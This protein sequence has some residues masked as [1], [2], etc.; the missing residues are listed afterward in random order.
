MHLYVAGLKTT[1]LSTMSPSTVN[2]ATSP[3]LTPK[4]VANLAG[5][6]HAVIW[7]IALGGLLLGI[8]VGISAGYFFWK[9]NVSKCSSKAT[10]DSQERKI[11]TKSVS[12]LPYL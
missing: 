2:D 5:M 8:V 6:S 4:I 12:L 9:N 1:K 10:Y 3:S 7:V 11:T